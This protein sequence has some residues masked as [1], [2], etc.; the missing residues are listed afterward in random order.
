MLSMEENVTPTV[1]PNDA[2]ECYKLFWKNYATFQGRARRSEFWW[3][4]L[5]NFILGSILSFIPI[6]AMLFGVAVL[7]PNLAIVSRRLH[8]TGRAFGWYFI[9]M[10]PLVGCILLIIWWAQEGQPGQNRFGDNPKG[11]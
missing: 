9:C 6:L 3:P 1:H 7:I 5:F 8:D 2:L 11:L 10:V 4:M